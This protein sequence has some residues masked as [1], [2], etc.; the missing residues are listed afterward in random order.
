VEIAAA[1]IQEQP[2]HDWWERGA[3]REHAG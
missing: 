3:P 1:M 2:P